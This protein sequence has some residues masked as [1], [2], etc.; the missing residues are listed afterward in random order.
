MT[1]KKAAV[2]RKKKATKVSVVLPDTIPARNLTVPKLREAYICAIDEPRRWA[3]TGLAMSALP[4]FARMAALLCGGEQCFF[5]GAKQEPISAEKLFMFHPEYPL[6]RCLAPFRKMAFDYV[7]QWETAEVKKS[8]LAQVDAGKIALDTP[9]YQYFCQ[10]GEGPCVVDVKTIAFGLRKHQKHSRRR[11]CNGCYQKATVKRLQQQRQVLS[12]P[13]ELAAARPKSGPQAKI[14]K[15]KQ[16]RKK[17][18]VIP[19]LPP[20]DA[21][22]TEQQLAELDKKALERLNAQE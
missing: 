17:G 5:C 10:C 11:L 12:V 16:A 2:K 7:E 9:V 20:I 19:P 8:I 1:S 22:L 4:K 13:P 15:I 18:T 21:V 3:R 6:C 14:N